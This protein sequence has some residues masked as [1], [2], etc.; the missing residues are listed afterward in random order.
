MTKTVPRILATIAGLRIGEGS[1]VTLMGAL[2]VSPESF[3]SGSIAPDLSTLVK[4][5]VHMVEAGASLV[6]VGALSTAPYRETAIAEEEEARRVAR[7]VNALVAELPV[8]VSADVSRPLPAK[9]ALEAGARILNDVTGLADPGVRALA[10]KFDGVILMA[11]SDGPWRGEPI[12]RVRGLLDAALARAE[13]SGV[14]AARIVLD[15]GIG[16]FRRTGRPWHEWDCGVLTRL[17]DLLPLGRPLCVAVSRKSFV[18]AIAGDAGPEERLPGSLAATAIAV[19]HGAHLIRTHD[20]A[21]TRQA[22]RVAEAI[23]NVTL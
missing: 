18:A 3:Y 23:R 2:N 8:P 19:L 17:R 21:E 9:A 1:A 14:P 22:V 7:A 16:F 11:S 4:Q 6:D 13:A 10:P 12:E 15:P 20:I 5:A